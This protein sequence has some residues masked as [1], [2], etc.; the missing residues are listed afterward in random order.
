MILSFTVFL[1]LNANIQFNELNVFL[2]N[3]VRK[4]FFH[5]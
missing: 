1:A 5:V 3:L 2:F 4:E